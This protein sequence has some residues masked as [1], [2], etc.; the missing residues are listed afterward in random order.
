MLRLQQA[1]AIIES[2][3]KKARDLKVRPLAVVV[4]DSAGNIIAAQREDGATM[5]Q[6]DVALGKAWGAIAMRASSRSLAD[7]AKSNPNF[8][9][10]LAASADGK[11]IPQTGAVLIRDGNGEILG[12]AGASG[13]G[14]GGDED[15]ACCVYGIEEA[16]LLAD[17]SE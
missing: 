14:H 16:G 7:R 8:F 9:S 1:N 15:E 5:F 3:L 12:A 4:L 11:L 17:D 6:F 2:A 10:A 13:G